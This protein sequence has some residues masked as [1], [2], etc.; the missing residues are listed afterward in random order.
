MNTCQIDLLEVIKGRGGVAIQTPSINANG[1]PIIIGEGDEQTYKTE[2]LT[3]GRLIMDLCDV[4]NSLH[5]IE[6]GRIANMAYAAL[7]TAKPLVIGA[8]AAKVL[9]ESLQFCQVPAAAARL[10]DILDEAFPPDSE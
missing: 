1:Q 8:G 4:Q 3:I 9:K 2:D 6:R 10:A 5:A 7:Q